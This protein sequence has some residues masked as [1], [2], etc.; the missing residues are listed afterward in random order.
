MSAVNANPLGVIT[1]VIWV[2][3]DGAQS[4]ENTKPRESPGLAGASTMVR[5]GLA[6][7]C[8]VQCPEKDVSS[9]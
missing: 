2:R 9:A 4:T 1:R 5:A 7:M 6:R 3:C 8:N